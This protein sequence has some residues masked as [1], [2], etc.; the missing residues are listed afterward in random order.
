MFKF[1]RIFL[2]IFL[3]NLISCSYLIKTKKNREALLSQYLNKM[4]AF[5]IDGVIEINYNQLAFRKNVTIIK[6]TNNAKIIIYEAGL[7][8]LKPEPF[9]SL[10]IRNDEI[11]NFESELLLNNEMQYT[12][13]F[14]FI[15][16][17]NSMKTQKD[18]IINNQQTNFRNYEFIFTD[19]MK[20]D[21]IHNYQ[22]NFKV[23]FSYNGSLNEL[24]FHK[25]NINIGKITVDKFSKME[26]ENN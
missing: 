15:N 3:I 22:E 13:M 16:M 17:F 21:K 4:Q 8:G 25:D 20:L 2:L 18:E 12:E 6:Q 26:K 10:T 19:D 11:I 23:E 1:R 24:I 7:F 5:R 9:I 14:N